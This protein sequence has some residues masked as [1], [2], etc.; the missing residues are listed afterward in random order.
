[1]Y[2]LNGKDFIVTTKNRNN[3]HGFVRFYDVNEMSPKES[4]TADNGCYGIS[5]SHNAVFIGNYKHSVNHINLLNNEMK[6]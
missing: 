1:M 6:M 4:F 5:V 3:L 2:P